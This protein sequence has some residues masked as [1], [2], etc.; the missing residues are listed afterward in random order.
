MA[1]LVWGL[2]RTHEARALIPT[3]HKP[4]VVVMQARN[5]STE[6]LAAE[7]PDIQCRPRL[8]TSLRPAWDMR[9]LFSKYI[10]AHAWSN[11]CCFSWKQSKSIIPLTYSSVSSICDNSHFSPLSTNHSWAV[12]PHLS[13]TTCRWTSAPPRSD[14]NHLVCLLS[15]G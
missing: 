3:P 6:Q 2:T 1:P 11:F 14:P 15:W 4:G 10:H 7:G 13:F 12:F 9:G 5:P 8:G